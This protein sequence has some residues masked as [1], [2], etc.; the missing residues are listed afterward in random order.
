MQMYQLAQTYRHLR[1]ACQRAD[2]DATHQQICT[3]LGIALPAPEAA[4]APR[5]EAGL[6]YRGFKPAELAMLAANVKPL[7][8]FEDVPIK[9]KTVTRLA[10]KQ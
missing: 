1:A 10:G 3:A 2:I 5:M 7:V 8:K 4:A 9:E 6:T